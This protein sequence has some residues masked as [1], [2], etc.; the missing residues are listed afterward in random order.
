M[1]KFVLVSLIAAVVLGCLFFSYMGS[2]STIKQLQRLT[3]PEGDLDAVEYSV[4]DLSTT[5]AYLKTEIVPRGKSINRSD[6]AVSSTDSI[7]SNGAY[8]YDLRWI[9]P[10][11]LEVSYWEGNVDVENGYKS[12][13]WPWSKHI[14]VVTK[15]EYPPAMED[16]VD[17]PRRR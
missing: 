15:R 14:T 11:T 4:Q 16:F 2:L 10:S 1:F 3:S 5:P 9:G 17:P 6:W 7:R 12:G 8:G 13:P